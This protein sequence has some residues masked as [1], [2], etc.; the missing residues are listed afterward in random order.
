MEN[1]R[2]FI[3]DF[4]PIVLALCAAVPDFY[5]AAVP[6]FFPAILALYTVIPAK[7]G[8]HSAAGAVGDA[9][10]ARASRP[11]SRACARLTLILTFS[12]EGRR[13]PLTAIH[14]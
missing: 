14:A 5:C 7:A 8:I 12:H 6:D 4:F 1:Y 2:A 3:P 10:G 11:H 13:D 9:L